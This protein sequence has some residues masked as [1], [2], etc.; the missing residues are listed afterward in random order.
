[1]CLIHFQNNLIYFTSYFL[2]CN[3]KGGLVRLCCTFLLIALTTPG[4]LS[5]SFSVGHSKT[6]TT[7]FK[8]PLS[9]HPHPLSFSLSSLSLT[10]LPREL[11]AEEASY[12]CPSGIT[13]VNVHTFRFMWHWP[14]GDKESSI[15]WRVRCFL[16]CWK[17]HQWG[18]TVRHAPFNGLLWWFRLQKAW[19]SVIYL[20]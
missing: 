9:L 4:I 10:P 6:D 12:L 8:T 5:L 11:C 1:M 15:L 2:G 3:P 7:I 16:R 20:R 19:L 18:H 14:V 17:H 13:G